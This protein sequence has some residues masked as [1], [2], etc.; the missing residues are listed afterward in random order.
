MKDLFYSLNKDSLTIIDNWFIIIGYLFVIIIGSIT[1][2]LTA[3]KEMKKGTAGTITTICLL[4]GVFFVLG[5]R[6]TEVIT[7]FGKLLAEANSGVEAIDELKKS[8]EQ[9]S[10][11]IDELKQENVLVFNETKTNLSK[12]K[13]EAPI[14]MEIMINDERIKAKEKLIDI[15]REYPD[16]PG[17]QQNIADIEKKINELKNENNSLRK[18]LTIFHDISLSFNAKH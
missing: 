18:Q 4:I 1:I 3:F 13:K 14:L 9:K 7:P 11:D 16:L 8:I 6:I 10:K 2:Y 17:T 15:D 12:I 5:N